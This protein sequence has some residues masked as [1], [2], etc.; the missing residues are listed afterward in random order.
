MADKLTLTYS[1][2]YNRVGKFLGLPFPLAGDDLTLVKDIVARGYRQFLYPIGG[3]GEL[4]IWSFVK[5]FYSFSTQSG[6]YKYELPD[7]FGDFIDKPHFDD[8]KGYNELT[9]IEPT[10]ILEIRAA[11]TSS[12]FPVYYAIAPFK[13]EN[14]IGTKY[15]LWLDPKPDGAYLLKGFYRID[16]TRPSATSDLLIG[17]IKSVEAILES[18]LAIAEQQENDTIGMHTQLAKGLVQDLIKADVQED[19]GY[20]GNLHKQRSNAL[21]WFSALPT[22]AGDNVYDGDDN[23]ESPY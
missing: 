7:D 17:G 6:R 14:S 10:Q 15:E 12:G 16:P 1:D 23:I 3:N 8:D 18:C 4:H 5:Q 2:L 13:Y 19:S 22:D 9:R 20:L 21:R 11:S